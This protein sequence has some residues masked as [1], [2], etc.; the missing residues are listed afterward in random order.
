MVI[1]PNEKA[2]QEYAESKNM[3]QSTLKVLTKGLY[4]F[5]EALNGKKDSNL[6]FEEVEHFLIGTAVDDRLTRGK[7]YFENKYYIGTSVKPSDTIMSIIQ[8]I[9]DYIVN[10]EEE[11][12]TTLVDV[13]DSLIMQAVTVHNYQSKWGN[14]ARINRVRLDGVLYYSELVKSFGKTILDSKQNELILKIVKSFQEGQLGG[15]YAS[16]KD[17][18]RFDLIFQF[19]I[20]FNYLDVPCKGLLDVLYVDHVEKTVTPIDIKTLSD[21][22][23][24]FHIALK[25][26]R[27][28]FQAAFYVEGLSQTIPLLYSKQYKILP[29]TF[30]V[31]STTFPG[32]QLNY[33][34]SARTLAIGKFGV[35]FPVDIRIGSSHDT[36]SKKIM[37]FSETIQL[38]KFYE[39][40]GFKEEYKIAQNFSKTLT[41]DFFD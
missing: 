1:F 8:Y 18:K 21:Y 20:Y 31:E 15:L 27:Y 35:K 6:Y 17:S 11:V 34:V 40:R 4:P 16:A 19:P 41:V 22:T 29:F 7:T 24:N 33:E 30:M 14:E 39:E 3:N 9:F 32:Q 13:P 23:L 28:D 25:K 36:Y 10:N 26:R 12:P 2:L 38:Y 5:L 37:G